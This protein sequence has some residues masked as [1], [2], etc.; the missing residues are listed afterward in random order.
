MGRQRNGVKRISYKSVDGTRLVGVLN[1]PPQ[2]RGFALMMHGM[3]VDKDEW[4]GFYADMAMELSR[5]GIGSLRFDFRGHGESGGT[6]LDVSIIGEILDVEASLGK[7]REY[8]KR[9][10]AFIATSLG[11]GPALITASKLEREVGSVVLIAPVLDYTLTFLRPR[12]EWA[13]ASFH[14]EAFRTM[15][16][17]GYLLL[18]GEFKLSPRLIEEFR[19]IRPYEALSSLEVPILLIHGDKDSMVPFSVSKKYFDANRGSK[20][21]VLRH[22]DHGFAD[23]GDDEGESEKSLANKARIFKE[24]TS[25]ITEVP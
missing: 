4:Q 5:Q 19:W 12:T 20:F 23:Y 2:P 22:A 1:L 11:A 14:A 7:L 16:R 21:V 10:V 24:V 13:R 3:A 9:K 25:W 17:K 6:S 15:K 18:N 8:W